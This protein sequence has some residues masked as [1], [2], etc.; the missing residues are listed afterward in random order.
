M[1]SY[2]LILTELIVEKWLY[3]IT[4]DICV[5]LN[6]ARVTHLGRKSNGNDASDSA[7][8]DRLQ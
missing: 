3:L 7:N 8:M 4:S 2:R 5:D 1:F 6:A